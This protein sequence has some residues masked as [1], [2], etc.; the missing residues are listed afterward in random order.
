MNKVY[1]KI[2]NCC[3]ECPSRGFNGHEFLC[4]KSSNAIIYANNFAFSNEGEFP[5]DCPLADFIEPE[6]REV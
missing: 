4:E 2:I 3:F 5:K 6:K 1:T